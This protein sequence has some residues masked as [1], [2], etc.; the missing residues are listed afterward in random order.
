MRVKSP[1]FT[2]V[3]DKTMTGEV[4][5]TLDG[6]H[7]RVLMDGVY[8]AFVTKQQVFNISP[9]REEIGEEVTLID[10][11]ALRTERTNLLKRLD[12]I[13]DLLDPSV[14]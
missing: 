4:I 12:E 13:E 5:S 6:D 1:L 11:E 8:S 10:D 9:T 14:F 3:A 7:Q 2:A